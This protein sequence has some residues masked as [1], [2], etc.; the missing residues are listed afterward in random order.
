VRVKRSTGAVAGAAVVLLA[1]TACAGSAK[2]STADG[3]TVS[4]GVLS[5]FTGRLASLGQSMLQGSEV[6]QKVVNDAGGVLGKKLDLAHADTSCDLADAVPATQSLLSKNVAGIIGPET[7]EIA[8]VEPILRSSKIVDEF[9]GGDTSRD[10]QTD[11]F[12][13]RDSPSDSQLGVAM[14]L[15]AHQK[16]YTNA[17]LLFY[18][19]VAAQTLLAPIQAAFEKLGGHI[20]K[21]VNVAPGQ[22]SYRA[23]VQDV[24][25]A[26]PDVIFTQ[27]DAPTAAV[28]FRE[29]QQANN[30]AIPMVGTDV[31][32]GSDYLKAITYPVAH[33]HL[34]S[35]Y[36]TSVTGQG[37]DAFLK[38]FGTLNAGQQPLANANYAYD[39]VIS[40]ALAETFAKTTDGT[41]VAKDMT[42]VT[43]PGGTACYTYTSCLTLLKAG[44]KINYEGASGSLDYNKYRNTFGSYGAF[45]SDAKGNELQVAN[46]SAAALG[47]ATP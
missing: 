43:N 1:L 2:G 12:L 16:G 30:L 15:Y 7:Q 31:T 11:Q 46:M 13:F 33:D 34:V 47:A 27:T 8:A 19:D 21:S 40:L 17:A 24:I 36:G 20:V 37:N 23:Q 42:Q 4:Y 10:K 26:H 22:T 25:S 39:A 6:A 29:L 5:C 35:I 3:A 38:A 44:K 14:A 32:S 41:T 45:S 9:Q 18:N 28:L